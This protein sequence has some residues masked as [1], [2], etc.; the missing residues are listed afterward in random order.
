MQIRALNPTIRPVHLPE[1]ASI[2]RTVTTVFALNFAFPCQSSSNLDA[3]RSRRDELLHELTVEGDGVP[4]P[5]NMYHAFCGL[6]F[7]AEMRQ[8][9]ASSLWLPYHE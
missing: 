1:N 7:I 9:V 3:L 6:D 8:Q 2:D 5:L 4:H